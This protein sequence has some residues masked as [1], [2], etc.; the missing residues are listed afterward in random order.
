MLKKAMAWDRE[1]T[2]PTAVCRRSHC[3][4]VNVTDP[5]GC[6]LC[7]LAAPQLYNT[8]EA[9]SI[10]IQT[11]YFS[12]NLVVPGIRPG[13]SGS[14]ASK[15]DHYTTEAVHNDVNNNYNNSNV[16]CKIG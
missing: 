13:T 1:R 6:V 14:V 9:E 7:F 12:E 16:M 3:S 11:H 15:S 5:Y 8:Y 2:I 4:V 10:P